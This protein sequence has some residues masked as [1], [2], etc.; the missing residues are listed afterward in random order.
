MTGDIA[1]LTAA[2]HSSHVQP[3]ACGNVLHVSS[4][5]H[6]RQV[7]ATVRFKISRYFDYIFH[8]TDC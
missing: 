8:R 2:E 7:T 1:V 6:Y 5:Y 4:N 3:S